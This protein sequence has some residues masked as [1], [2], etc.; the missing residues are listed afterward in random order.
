MQITCQ[1]IITNLMLNF[2]R[3]SSMEPKN[4]ILARDFWIW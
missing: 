4:D 2:L 1:M 3:S